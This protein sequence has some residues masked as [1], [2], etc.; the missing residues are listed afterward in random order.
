MKKL[1]LEGSLIIV[2]LFFASLS[3]FLIWSNYP[4]LLK[5]QFFFFLIGLALFILFSQVDSLFLKNFS[6]IFYFVSL[7]FL[8]AT[9]INTEVRGANR[10]F[11]IFGV[12]IQPSE[13][14]KPFLVVSFANFMTQ[15]GKKTIVLILQRLIFYFLPLLFIFLQ[16]D[17]GNFIIYFS[18]LSGMLIANNLDVKFIIVF[19]VAFLI[20]TPLFWQVL[21][22]YQRERFLSFINPQS[23]PQGSGYNAIQSVIAVGSGGL[24]GLGL[25]RGTQSHLKFLPESH[26]DFI[27]ASL[28]EELGLLGAIIPLTLYFYVLWTILKFA[29]NSED[30]FSYLVF[31]GIF[32]QLLSQIFINISMNMGLLPITGITL[33]LIS[34]GGSSII[35]TFIALGIIVA[36]KKE[37]K[38]PALVI[39]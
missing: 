12:R 23:D 28:T 9:L 24:F 22:D 26:T 15:E 37:Q 7:V 20:A 6:F 35:A 3:L 27:F 39:R 25:G 2:S 31:I 34:Y 17:L 38:I 30:K 4:Q 5:T 36:L 16:P 8:F 1:Y 21:K 14:A 10:W 13:I 19:L 29:S 11:D 18:F 33:P 32:F